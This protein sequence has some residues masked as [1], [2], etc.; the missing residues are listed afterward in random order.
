MLIII[1]QPTKRV[2]LSATLHY[3][4]QT[5]QVN[6]MDKYIKN[7][8]ELRTL[9]TKIDPCNLDLLSYVN[10]DWIHNAALKSFRFNDITKRDIT[11]F[12]KVMSTGGVKASPE[13][14]HLY[15]H[16][17]RLLEDI[18]DDTRLVDVISTMYA[19]TNANKVIDLLYNQGWGDVY[20]HDPQSF[21][22]MMLYADID[23]HDIEKIKSIVPDEWARFE[24]RYTL[25][26]S[27][28]S[29]EWQVNLAIDRVDLVIAITN[30]MMGRNK[31]DVYQDTDDVYGVEMF[32]FFLPNDDGKVEVYTKGVATHIIKTLY[33]SAVINFI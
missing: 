32:V 17:D 31:I 18:D 24:N 5:K 10:T 8:K 1:N 12:K 29:E 13:V 4:Q 15:E 22:M 19:D 23:Q 25:L 27:E 33:P 14:W 6:K 16:S 7:L 3:N 28:I 20:T 2:I 30:K 11:T 21:G 26:P 9:L